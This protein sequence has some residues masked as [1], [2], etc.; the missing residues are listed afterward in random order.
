MFILA[1][2]STSILQPFMKL[3][4]RSG[5]ESISDYSN[6]FYNLPLDSEFKGF[7]QNYVNLATHAEVHNHNHNVKKT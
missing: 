3:D 1:A 2:S 4:G 6:Y 5:L 7:I